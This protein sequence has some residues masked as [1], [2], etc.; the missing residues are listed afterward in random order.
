MVVLLVIVEG[1]I[2]IQV[3]LSAVDVL[4]RCIIFNGTKNTNMA[5]QNQYKHSW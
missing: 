1:E 4:L 5:A 2:N 3:N